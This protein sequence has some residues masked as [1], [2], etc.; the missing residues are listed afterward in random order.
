MF[1]PACAARIPD[2]AT[3]CP[4]CGGMVT[5][6]AP[7]R[8]AG[9]RRP[10]VATAILVAV[11][12]AAALLVA[13]TAM[14]S[15]RHDVDAARV[16]AEAALSA[17]DYRA[18]E[19]WLGR[20]PGDAAARTRAAILL[21]LGP[22]E[23]L[24]AAGDEAVADGDAATAAARFSGANRLLPNIGGAGT[25][26]VAARARAI[27]QV[28]GETAEAVASGRW[29]AAEQAAL[30]AASLDPSDAGL[31]RSW[32]DIRRDHAQ[33]LLRNGDG[34]ALVDPSDGT[35]LPL[36]TGVAAAR[37]AWSPDRERV[38]FLTDDETAYPAASLWV[39]NL[40][41][42]PPRRL[43]GRVHPNAITVWSPDG[44]SIAYTGVAD[45]DSA[46][47]IDSL[48]V[49]V[50]DANTGVDRNVTA[51]TGR[52]AVTPTWSPDGRRLA[53]VARPDD[54][55]SGS[56]RSADVMTVDLAT[57]DVRN[58]TRGR[59]PGV[60]RVLWSPAGDQLLA[61]GPASTAQAATGRQPLALATIDAR[62]GEIRSVR[63]AVYG[64]STVW[65]PAW[66]PDG[67]RFAFVDR[68]TDVVVVGPEGEQ[69]LDSDQALLGTVSW[70]P[71]G[72]EFLVPSADP[73]RPSVVVGVAGPVLRG[74]PLRLAF[75][76]GA[77]QGAPQWGPT[78][79]PTDPAPPGR[80]GTSLDRDAITDASATLPD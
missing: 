51:R 70:S 73:A 12:I 56:A 26:A 67:R 14:L 63:D 10:R 61:Y 76:P 62:T 30:A 57:L 40:D 21:R 49:H 54:G 66:S 16:R 8:P 36:P 68:A 1:C 32:R 58:L 42:T 44:R 13:A 46:D 33:V 28:R 15:E 69:R 78:T 55:A 80:F 39:T 17:G 72:G 41:G 25:R 19:Q 38:A 37:P 77:P 4:A 5:A 71:D 48:A 23:R 43:V 65:S 34:V 47:G 11:P 20:V 50:V 9:S 24:L 29:R 53:F 31:V 60:V 18:A 52:N 2:V 79:Q 3:R 22:A 45:R 35:S 64:T 27:A 6:A 59:F 75:T 7:S 74:R